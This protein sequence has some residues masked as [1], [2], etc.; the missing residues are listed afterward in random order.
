MGRPWW[1]GGRPCG[2]RAAGYALDALDALVALTLRRIERIAHHCL[3]R[4]E[5]AGEKEGGEGI[6]RH[7]APRLLITDAGEEGRVCH[8]GA[9]CV[10]TLYASD[11][12]LLLGK[13]APPSS[14]AAL[15]NCTALLA[16]MTADPTA[17]GLT[18]RVRRGCPEGMRAA[19]RAALRAAR[20]ARPPRA[21]LQKRGKGGPKG[22][23]GRPE[24]RPGSGQGAA[25]GAAL[26]P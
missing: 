17:T 16:T 22:R 11:V 19:L 10:N 5:P 25:H 13:P 9:V 7:R 26:P 20:P 1:P 21:A 4:L 8:L 24:G 15:C 18:S 12:D 14:S 6:L 23:P 3:R 2:S